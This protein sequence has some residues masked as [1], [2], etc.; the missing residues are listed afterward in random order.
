M[1]D[2]AHGVTH[3]VTHELHVEVLAVNDAPVVRAP[4]VLRDRY[5]AEGDGLDRLVVGVRPIVAME[6]EVRMHGRM[7]GRSA[8]L[9]M[10]GSGDSFT[11]IS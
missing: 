10:V 2:A 7:R 5:A 3:T 4:G 9:A 1:T 11:L 8:C 6:D